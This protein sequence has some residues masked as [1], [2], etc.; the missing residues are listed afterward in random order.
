MPSG[1]KTAAGKILHNSIWYGLETVLETIIF[2]GTSIA[3]ARYLGPEKNGA[4]SFINFFVITATRTS[5]TGVASATRKFMAE[6]LV[7]DRPGAARGV[8]NVAYLYQLI[9]ALIIALGGLVMVFFFGEPQYRLMSSILLVAVIPGVMSWVP[10][11]ANNAFEDMYPN[12]ISAFGYLVCYF[13]VI[14]LTIVFH[15]DLVGI[16]CATLIGRTAEVVLRTIPLHKRFRQFPLEPATDEIKARIRRYCTQGIGVQILTSIVYDRSEFFFLKYFSG[17]AAVGFYSVSAG[18]VDRLL[19]IPR[20]FGFATGAT[21]VVE[22]TRDSSRMN[23][24]IRNTCRVLLFVVFPI[25]LGAAAIAKVAVAVGYGSRYAP[26]APVMVIAALLGMPRAFQFISENLLRAADKQKLQLNWL[27]VTGVINV[28]LDYVLIR[29]YGAVGAAWGNGISQAF[30]TIALWM[31]S[32]SVYNIRFPF[33]AA[34]RYFG[35]AAVMAVVTFFVSRSVSPVPGFIL[36]LAAGTVTYFV[37]LKLLRAL[38]ASDRD[39]LI[40]ITKRFPARIQK[41]LSAAVAYIAA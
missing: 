29:R 1:E 14:V 2:F 27:I 4:F 41:P 35:A 9:G 37:M 11:E 34:V 39:R 16:A 19:L 28:A 17:D 22:A 24:L 33:A 21:I 12:T 26:A 20:T 3:V 8:Y 13:I 31:A 10:A 25:H 40:M 18:L 23:S 32:R 7:I 15:W 6:Y 36:G 38:D 30:A 5:G